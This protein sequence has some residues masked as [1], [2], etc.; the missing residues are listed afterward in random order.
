MKHLEESHNQLKE[1]E[2][3]DIDM[4]IAKEIEAE[5]NALLEAIDRRRREKELKV[6]RPLMKMASL[7]SN[8]TFSDLSPSFSTTWKN[9]ASTENVK[10]PS[11]KEIMSGDTKGKGNRKVQKQVKN[12]ASCYNAINIE[13]NNKPADLNNLQAGALLKKSHSLRVR[14]SKSFQPEKSLFQGYSPKSL[15]V[16]KPSS[17][18]ND[19]D[20][21]SSP[22]ITPSSSNDLQSKS[23]R[24]SRENNSSQTLTRAGTNSS[25][26]STTSGSNS[27]K[28][29]RGKRSVTSNAPLNRLASVT[30]NIERCA[31]E[32]EEDEPVRSVRS[33]SPAPVTTITSPSR[34]V[35]LSNGMR[36][37]KLSDFLDEE[38]APLSPGVLVSYP[39]FSVD[40][41][42]EEEDL[43]ML[44]EEDE[45][46][47][48]EEMSL[49][50]AESWPS[51]E[52][53][54]D[55]TTSNFLS[56]L[57]KQSNT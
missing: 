34:V 25:T 46:R 54:T 19:I 42:C 49:A 2:D 36:H 40:A 5:R 41:T 1:D 9:V 57:S 50:S 20:D 14:P 6:R 55:T 18:V 22:T 56:D 31:T 16:M 32:E 43:R 8:F 4:E 48:K 17:E 21:T 52:L 12:S 37:R 29:Q 33:I 38:S 51:T 24:K 45:D 47:N 23:R 3:H 13:D 15:V 11:N 53:T 26:R 44:D 27:F 39:E 30:I 7:P 10:M 28:G 35:K